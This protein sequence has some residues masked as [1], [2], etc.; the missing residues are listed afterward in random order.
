MNPGIGEG[1]DVSWNWRS[2]RLILELEKDE[3]NPGTGE[4]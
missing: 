3:M 4:G 2:L 1:W